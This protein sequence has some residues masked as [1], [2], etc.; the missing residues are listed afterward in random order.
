MTSVPRSE[1]LLMARPGS[2]RTRTLQYLSQRGIDPSRIDFVDYQPRDAYLRTYH[3]IDVVLDTYPYNGHTT[4]LDA[5][6]MG[7]PV[8]SLFGRTAV[9]RAGLSQLSN[10]ELENLAT[11]D[12][13]RFVSIAASLAAD[14]RRLV[15]VHSTL[16]DRMLRS[17]LTDAKS[18][19][20]GIESAYERMWQLYCQAQ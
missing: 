6:W 18:F 1:L 10:L 17:P 12:R 13:D 14:Q 15:S 11:D 4:N 19:T 8:V 5:L 20:R 16:R 3:R 7:V 9:S 2:P